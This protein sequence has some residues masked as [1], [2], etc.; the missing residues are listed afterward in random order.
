M[1][2]C[3]NC[4]K[5][6]KG[7][8]CNTSCQNT[9]RAKLIRED[10]YK[11][12]KYCKN[13]SKLIDFENKRNTYCSHSCSATK[14]NIGVAR[15]SVGST[16]TKLDEFSDIDF[17]SIV[18]NSNSW[19]EIQEHLNYKSL[20]PS[21]KTN[22]LKRANSLNIEINFEKKIIKNGN[23]QE[24]FN[25]SKNWQS[26]RSTIRKDAAKVY[27]GSGKEYKCIICGYDL[28]IEIAHIKAVSEFSEQSTLEEINNIN[29]L[30]ALCPN[31]HWEY[32]NGVLQI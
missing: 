22:I 32:D 26:A 19:K 1:N 29:N 15:N 5:E 21:Q 16:K 6:V 23:K 28:H 2:N 11:N 18:K 14:N 24:I 7:K 12:P 27:K 13:C 3:L 25:Q 10:Y 9:H 4:G 8:Y 17:I 20:K 30:I 31:H